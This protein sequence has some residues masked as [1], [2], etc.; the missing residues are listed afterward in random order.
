MKK[1][2]ERRRP[3]EKGRWKRFLILGL[4]GCMS[5]SM[6]ANVLKSQVSLSLK[7][8]TL[9]EALEQVQKQVGVSIIYS[10]NVLDDE[11]KVSCKTKN[12]ELE[13]VLSI[14]L[15]NQNCAYKV[16]NGQVIL[17]P[18]VAEPR[19]EEVNQEGFKV[20]GQVSDNMGPL[21]GVN[22]M[23][24]GTMTG[25]ITDA[26]GNYEIVAPYSKASLIFSYVGFQPQEVQL[27]G[28]HTL[29]V[30][31][32]EDTKA[33]EE[34]VVVGYT[35]QRKATITGAVSTITTK[36]LTQSPTANLTNALA[37]R[38][39]GLMVNQFSGGEPGVDGADIKIRGFGTYGD[40]SPIIIVDGVERDMSYLAPEEIE[41][42][43]ILK[44]ASATAPYGV[45]GANGV[46]IITTKRG[47]A[48]EKASVNF[49]ASVGTNNPVKFPSYLGS[50]DYATLYNEAMINGGTSPNSPDLFSQEAI[51][52]YRKAKGDNSDGMGYDWDYFDYA[53]KPG[54]QQDYSL[55]VRGGSDRARYYVLANYFQQ[56]GNYKHTDLTQ[57]D[58]QAVFKRYNFRANMDVDITKDFYVKLDL[59]ARITDRNAPG[60]TASRVVAIANTQPPYLPITLPNNGNPEN[61]AY[62]LNNPYGMLYGDYQHRYNILGELSR[63]GYLNEKKTFL[64]GSF[65]IG[66]K[67]DFITKGLK[68]E[69]IFSYDAEEGRWIKREL[70]QYDD[71]YR[72]FTKY[73]TF[74]PEAGQYGS[75]YMNNTEMY[76]GKYIKGN[77]DYDQDATIGNEL[78]H[79]PTQNRTYYQLKLDYLRSFGLHDVSGL[80]LFNRS[81]RAYD[82][83]VEYRYQGLSGRATY[84]YDNKYLAEFNIGYNG[85]ENFA[86][87]K[88]YGTF[89][90]GSIGWVVSR[91][92]FMQSTSS[93]LDNLKIR[94][95]Y[96]LVGSDQLG[97][98]RFAYLSFFNGGGG[99]NTGINNDFGTG[100]A[101]GYYEGNLSN[102]NLTWEK[103]KK[104]NVGIDASFFNNRLTFTMD[105]F[106]EH[107][108]DIITDLSG[109]DKLGYPNYV[110]KNAPLINS[111]IVDN[112]GVD[113]EVGWRGSIGRDFHYYI[114]PNF[115]F[116]RNKIIFMNEVPRDF[117]W[118]AA[119][120]KRIDENFVYV[121]DH[122][123]YDQAE[124]DRLNAMN[125]GAGFQPWGKLSPGD[126]VYKDLDGDG[127]ISDLNDR[128]NM[129][130]PRTP[131]IQFGIPFGV[132]YKGFDLSVML[133][134]AANTSM[135]L[136]GAA[137]WDFPAYEQDQIGK[138]KPM[139]MNRWTEETKDFATYPRLTIGKNDN[140]KNE[141]SSLFLYNASYLRVKNVEIGYTLPKSAIRFAGLQNVRFYVQGMNLLTFD[142]LDDV[143]VDPET[144]NG[145]G[146]WYP[147]Q[148][149]FNF[150]ID[151]TY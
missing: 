6:Y 74:T 111:G 60:T 72:K 82:K 77:R 107:R 88:R 85:S 145:S 1:K 37:G 112:K 14:L 67:L 48:Q 59:G 63:T 133:Q 124:A 22:V 8:A 137:V 46:I 21:P 18:K 110:G 44:D 79:N 73:G 65:A 38:M 7:N 51:E 130:N 143:D 92:S 109:G 12:A 26:D 101:G 113:I 58:T 104:L 34:V 11:A 27:K 54:M 136:N 39:P 135:L 87:G 24:K 9:K 150:G 36:D 64:N 68:I 97:G 141:S 95:S 144:R 33:L 146:D 106:K 103:S 96:G 52:R 23:V 131:E 3:H 86:P 19:V 114:K 125:D 94:A 81:S 40:K 91:E 105:V 134:G 132:Q 90:A 5:M 10:N 80:I 100:M 57:F 45:R 35:T 139:H 140:N 69:G 147:I 13:E 17:F 78:S 142:G 20:K 151:I 148:R 41:T 55:S 93:W 116:A 84:A 16:E 138:V 149:V 25:V 70:G 28:E 126:V 117:E 121:F 108:F 128:T 118:R 53:F 61:E 98:S 56:D 76:P 83:D 32:V 30:T 43:T 71:G 127:K 4:C 2:D 49:K 75:Y 120:G 122:F 119:T 115:T 42:F 129:G 89:P 66:H 47:K 29:N 15:K 99:Y 102:P 50:A 123:V 62:V 31:L